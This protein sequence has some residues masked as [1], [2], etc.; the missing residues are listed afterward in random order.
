MTNVGK[1]P[2]PSAICSGCRRAG[3]LTGIEYI[4]PCPCGGSLLPAV[5]IGQFKECSFCE[6]S[7]QTQAEPCSQCHGEG[8]VPA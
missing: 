8:W 4:E 3:H 5:S 6:A 7:G 2:L 1:M